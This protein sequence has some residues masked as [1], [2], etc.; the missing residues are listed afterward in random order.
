[1]SFSL[2]EHNWK[3][4]P[5]QVIG[6]AERRYL[7]W[8]TQ[9]TPRDR[10]LGWGQEEWKSISPR[11]L[12]VFFAVLFNYPM[13]FAMAS[14]I[15]LK[16]LTQDQLE[17]R[18]GMGGLHSIEPTAF[19]NML[20]IIVIAKNLKYWRDWPIE[21][22]I[23]KL[24]NINEINRV[25]TQTDI[26]KINKVLSVPSEQYLGAISQGERTPQYYRTARQ[27]LH[28]RTHAPTKIKY[29]QYLNLWEPKQFLVLRGILKQYHVIMALTL[30]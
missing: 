24:T 14:Y 9:L 20:R 13:S 2:G 3:G 4:V 10:T 7:L 26:V 15:A 30:I 5:H 11:D 19:I 18:M 29:Q 23:P 28:T 27:H 17:H 6:I 8:I 1:M 21:L 16:Q 12:K 22:V 25:A